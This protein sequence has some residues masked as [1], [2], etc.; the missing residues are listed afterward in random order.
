MS[1][2]VKEKE[3][4]VEENHT[5][6]PFPDGYTVDV[7]KRRMLLWANPVEYVNNMYGCHPDDDD[8]DYFKTVYR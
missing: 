7:F 4:H 3:V 6:S 1:L 8:S 2:S 5:P